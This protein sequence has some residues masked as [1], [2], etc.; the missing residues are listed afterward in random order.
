[1]ALVSVVLN[2]KAAYCGKALLRSPAPPGEA[3]YLRTAPGREAPQLEGVFPSAE[4]VFLPLP[5][6]SVLSLVVGVLF[7]QVPALSEATV[8]QGLVDLLR[9]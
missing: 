8:A 5:P 1:M 4:G 6:L 2:S 9:P 7:I 3:S